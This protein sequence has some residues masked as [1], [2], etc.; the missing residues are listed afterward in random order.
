MAIDAKIYFVLECKHSHSWENSQEAEV[1]WNINE[2]EYVMKTLVFYLELNI[3]SHLCIFT[4][5]P[6]ALTTV[7]KTFM[8]L[9][10][11]CDMKK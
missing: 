8:C 7:L 2:K 6:T 5:L 9:D 10:N 1:W 4:T 11:I 3:A